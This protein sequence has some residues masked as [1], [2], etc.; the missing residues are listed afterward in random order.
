MTLNQNK[1][2][3][4]LKKIMSLMTGNDENK[5]PEVLAISPI[6]LKHYSFQQSTIF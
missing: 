6:N 2:N 3:Q 5:L 4:A 1:G